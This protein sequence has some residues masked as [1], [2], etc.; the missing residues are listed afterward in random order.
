[1]SVPEV[2]DYY[3]HNVRTNDPILHLEE[4]RANK[5]Y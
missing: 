3:G 1:M 4:E 5:K 2:Y